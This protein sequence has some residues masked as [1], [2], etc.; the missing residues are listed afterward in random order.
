MKKIKLQ[1]NDFSLSVRG[2]CRGS[3][4]PDLHLDLNTE[5]FEHHP[6]RR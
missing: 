4:E 5:L 6:M 3:G 2:M 1:Y